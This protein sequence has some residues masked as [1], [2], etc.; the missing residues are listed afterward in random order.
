MARSLSDA[1]GR[2]THRHV[3]APPHHTIRLGPELDFVEH[4]STSRRAACLLHFDGQLGENA[5]Y[6]GRR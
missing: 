5:G 6:G 2:A 3:V 1:Q 4:A